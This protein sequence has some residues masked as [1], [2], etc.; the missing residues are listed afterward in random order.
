MGLISNIYLTTSDEWVWLV[1]SIN[2]VGWDSKY[3]YK[4][5]YKHKHKPVL[6][7]ANTGSYLYSTSIFTLVLTIRK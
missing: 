4:Y 1:R 3:K 6:N 7:S 2:R 5:K